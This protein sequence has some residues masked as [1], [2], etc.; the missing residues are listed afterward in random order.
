MLGNRVTLTPMLTILTDLPDD[1]LDASAGGLHQIL[2]GPT[3]IHLPGRRAQPLFVCVLLHGNEDTGLKAV[4]SVLGNYRDRELPRALSLFIGNVE[5]AAQGQRHLEGQPD[6]NRVWPGADTSGLPEHAMMLE[7]VEQMR[8]RRVFASIDIHNNT[9]VN[10]HYGCVN[11]LEAP[12]LHL[13]T[14]FSR[15]VVYFKRPLGVQSAAFAALC[16][17]VTVECGKA[18][19]VGS[20][21]H[22]AAF[23][24][25]ALRLDHL[26]EHPVPKHDLAL[27]HTVATVKVPD[28]VR[29][30]F[31]GSD[32][33]VWF[34]PD[35]D[36]MNFRDLPAGTRLGKVAAA[37]RQP[38][39]ALDEEGC[40][41]FENYFEI[42]GGEL[43]TRRP[44]TPSMLTLNEQ[45]IR[46]DCLCYLM[47]KLPYEG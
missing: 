38:L 30:A 31:G 23:L 32:A 47:E 21:T 39:L 19:N 4:Q 43:R 46:Q 3:L 29:F 1:F 15:V 16:P 25:A 37:C 9:G 26:P 36:H 7:V 44:V 14:L 12:V 35:L 40:D 24:E 17:S 13:A 34:E 27:Y 18:G 10:P 28:Q 20:E 41:V 6:Y 2:P 42:R 5:A 11:R 33:Q 45:V 8:A 22:A